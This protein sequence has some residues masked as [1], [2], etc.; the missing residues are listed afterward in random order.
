MLISDIGEIS[1]ALERFEKAEGPFEKGLQLFRNALASFSH[2]IFK[3][4]SSGLSLF[5]CKVMIECNVI[6][7]CLLY[8]FVFSNQSLKNKSYTW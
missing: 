8:N 6:Y 4:F 7:V 3:L 5:L 2:I 1:K